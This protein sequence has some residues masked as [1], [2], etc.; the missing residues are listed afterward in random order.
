MLRLLV[1]FLML[2]FLGGTA[3]GAV[4]LA[5]EGRQPVTLEEVYFHNGIVFLAL[6]D[7]L[8]P[9]ELS[10]KWD[11]VDHVYR[12]RT[13][14]GVA[15]I[16]PGSHFLRCGEM[17]RPLANPPRFIDG[18]L[19]VDEDFVAL[20]LP[21]LLNKPVYF[22][23]LDADRE[24][25]PAGETPIDRLFAFILR[26]DRPVDA[27]VLRAVAIDPGHGGQ[28]PG[29]IAD[30]GLKEK[31]IV[32]DVSRRLEKQLKMH[33]GIP[34]YLT[35]NSDYTLKPADRLAAVNQPN[36]DALVLLHAQSSFSEDARGATLFIRPAGQQP[37]VDGVIDSGESLR[38][39]R[40]LAAN[41]KNAGIRVNGIE[42]APLLPLGKGNLPSV[43]V[44]LGYL[45]NPAD[46]AL[47]KEEASRER[48][49]AAL[50]QGLKA[51]AEEKKEV[52]G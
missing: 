46:R 43:L 45:S 18:K 35:R 23:Q 4:E 40:Q 50:Y 16:S 48:L 36:V 6:E 49:A 25:E 47:L 7:V 8:A 9:L 26:K 5:L 12:I 24:T 31:D 2:A 30:E 21:T 33:L 3:E 42:Q 34:V 44:E 51:Y 22:H 52:G 10:G 37:G 27:P 32:L 39:A 29:S 28:D 11:S 19:R 13:P 17:L 41:L 1:V 14:R 15:V 20:H 38:L